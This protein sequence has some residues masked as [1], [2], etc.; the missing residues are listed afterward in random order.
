MI[1]AAIDTAAVLRCVQPI[2]GTKP[3]TDSRA[4]G[5]IETIIDAARTAPRTAPAG[6]GT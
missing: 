2:W 1:I 6:W 4:R 5:R 3:E